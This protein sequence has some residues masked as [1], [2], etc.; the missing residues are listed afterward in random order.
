MQTYDVIII[1]GGFLGLSSAYQLA[2][3]GVRTLLLEAGDIGGGT[4]ASCAGRAQ[5]CE[6]HL[7]PLNIK[8]IRD[9]LKKHESLEEE[10]GQSYDW[11][12]VGLFLL[13][14]N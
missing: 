7:D 13:I 11:R 2:R 3:M 12:R 9:G 4:S 6:G 5:V 10:L 14:K 8:L 1:G